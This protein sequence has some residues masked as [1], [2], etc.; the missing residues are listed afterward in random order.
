MI[1]NLDTSRQQVLSERLL[2][3]IRQNYG[4][5]FWLCLH[6]HMLAISKKNVNTRLAAVTCNGRSTIHYRTR[7]NIDKS[8]RVKNRDCPD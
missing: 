6:L 7:V 3:L 5:T 4:R 2:H 1:E 8:T